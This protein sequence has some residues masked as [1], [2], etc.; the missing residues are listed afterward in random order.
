MISK[1]ALDEFK[2]IYFQEYGV[3]LTDKEVFDKAN[4][5]LL[6]FKIIY[7]PVIEKS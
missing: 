3:K 1:K 2:D 6:I 4:K 5:L 7:N